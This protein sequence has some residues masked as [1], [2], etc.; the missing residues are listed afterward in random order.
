MYSIEQMVLTVTHFIN[1]FKGEVVHINMEQ[2]NNFRNVSLLQQAYNHAVRCMNEYDT[3]I[4][5]ILYN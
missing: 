1:I 5:I 4:E 3:R 2:F